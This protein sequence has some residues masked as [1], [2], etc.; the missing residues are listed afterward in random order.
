M[1]QPVTQLG[2]TLFFRIRVWGAG[3]VAREGGVVLA[4]N[5]A[6]FL[7]PPAVGLGLPRPIW[8]MARASLFR[9]PGFRQLIE[10]L[11]A[12]P[13]ERGGADRRAVRR[14]VELLR[15][16][17]ALL[18]FPEGTRSRDGR[19]G[20]FGAGFAMMAARAGVPVVPVA[21]AGTFEAWPRHRALPRAGRVAVAFGEPVGPPE[22]GREACRAA[23]AAVRRRVVALHQELKGR[24]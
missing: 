4:S 18:V 12:L 14:A 20:R 7:D 8:Y 5:H 19:V 23:A 15:G 24:E 9:V 21:L 1:A 22:G 6:S 17:G 13:I 16:G 3:H 11:N 2:F 10:A